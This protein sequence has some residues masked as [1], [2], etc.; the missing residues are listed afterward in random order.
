MVHQVF[1]PFRSRKL[2]APRSTVICPPQRIVDLSSIQYV[3]TKI[4]NRNVTGIFLGFVNLLVIRHGMLESPTFTSM[5]FSDQNL[6]F[7]WGF[8]VAM[9][10]SRMV[11]VAHVLLCYFCINMINMFASS[12]DFKTWNLI[13][14]TKNHVPRRYVASSPRKQISERMVFMGVPLAIWN[15]HGPK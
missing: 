4:K 10:D 2:T 8:P 3:P 1:D 15:C 6:H 11:C 12:K 5:Y 13:E 9:F 7:L 14:I